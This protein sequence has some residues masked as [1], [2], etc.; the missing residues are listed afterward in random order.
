MKP[1][2]VPGL[3]NHQRH[4]VTDPLAADHVDVNGPRGRAAVK[5]P[6][7]AVS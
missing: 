2:L 7:G 3:R 5:R 1:T 6:T 4:E